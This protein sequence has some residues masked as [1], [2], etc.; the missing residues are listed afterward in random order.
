MNFK[1]LDNQPRL[2]IEADL[3]PVQGAR[4]QPTGFPDLG[5]AEF[6]GPDG[7]RMLLVESA[8]SVANHLERTVFKEFSRDTVSEV[9]RPGF[10]G[11]CLV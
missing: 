3:Q 2:L 6:D 1:A 7:R 10:H 9:N 8:Q 11:G 5:A 4:F